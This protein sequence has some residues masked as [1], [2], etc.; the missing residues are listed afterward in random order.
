VKL[1]KSARILEKIKLCAEEFVAS[2]YNN[3]LETYLKNKPLFCKTERVKLQLICYGFIIFFCCWISQIL[4]VQAEP[5]TSPKS[6]QIGIY[7]TSL[8]DFVPSDKSFTATFWVWSVCPSD[9]L[10]PLENLKILNSNEVNI[11]Y[12][13]TSPSENRSDIFKANKTVF[14]SEQEISASLY[15]DWDTRNYPF[16][17][18]ELQI[19]LEETQ[20]DASQFVHIPDFANTSYQKD[21]NLEGWEISNFKISQ[22]NFPYQTGFGNPAKKK[23]ITNRSRLVVS[24]TI[25][26][27][28]RVSFFKLSAGVYAA[29]A[30]SIVTLLLDEDFGDRMGIFVGTLF[31]VL[32]NMQTATS[33][34]GS[35]N[36]VTLIDFIH[37]MAIVYIFVTAILLVYTRFLSEAEQESFSRYLMRRIM[38]PVLGGSF[39][40]L[41]IVI[42]A[43]AVIVG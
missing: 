34:L 14:W 27:K 11:N 16:D 4:P 43:Y 24:I 8:R 21:M 17:R 6:C 10:K 40:I 42:I 23:E 30:L 25:N 37:I 19:I 9:T 3:L 1:L 12:S 20:L 26:R 13:R 18:H 7:L 38:V 33:D 2:F 31:A 22:E 28:N 39:A 29:V 32:V 36:I 5:L 15:Y 41:N 35:T